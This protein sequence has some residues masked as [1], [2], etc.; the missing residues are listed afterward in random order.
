MVI[1]RWGFSRAAVRAKGKSVPVYIGDQTR[2]EGKVRSL[3]CPYHSWTYDLEGA[4]KHALGGNFEKHKRLV[5][6]TWPIWMYVSV[7]GV[8]VYFMLY[9]W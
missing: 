8:A 1:N 7:T 3:V 6:F 9:H 5:K 2:G 4:L